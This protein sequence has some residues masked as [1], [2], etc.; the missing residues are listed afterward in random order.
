VIEGPVIRHDCANLYRQQA[1]AVCNYYL[2]IAFTNIA[3]V[4]SI[5][6]AVALHATEEEMTM[7]AG[8]QCSDDVLATFRDMV[9]GVAATVA[10][11]QPPMLS[12]VMK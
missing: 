9:T 4:S 12:S 11:G 7:S 5:P 8:V 2:P 6:A 10:I 1:G 3:N